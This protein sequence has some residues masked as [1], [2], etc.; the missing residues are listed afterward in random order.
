[1]PIIEGQRMN[2]ASRQASIVE[3]RQVGTCCH[4]SQ[5]PYSPPKLHPAHMK[6]THSPRSSQP[7][8]HGIFL[9]DTKFLATFS[10]TSLDKRS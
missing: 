6:H 10:I 8:N 2:G 4:F 7:H 9:I 1:M 3:G 5:S